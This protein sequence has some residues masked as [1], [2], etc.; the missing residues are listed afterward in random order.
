M[1]CRVVDTIFLPEVTRG[2]R[3]GNRYVNTEHKAVLKVLVLQSISPLVLP[4]VWLPA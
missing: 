4:W 3:V 1:M 2:G